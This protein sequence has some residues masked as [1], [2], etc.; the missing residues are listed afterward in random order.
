MKKYDVVYILKKDAPADELRYS[1]RSV[2][3]NLPYRKIW[4]YCGKPDGIEPDEYVKHIQTGPTKWERAKSSVIEICKNDDITEKFWL[5]N[6]DF[7]ILQ[8]IRSEE[9][10]HRGLLRDH[11]R[12]VESRH[13]NSA[14]LYTRELRRCYGLL[15][16]AGY[17][18]LSYAIHAPMLVERAKM[19]EALKA[20][21]TCPMF[22]SIYGNYAK[23]GGRMQKDYKLLNTTDKPDRDAP[24]LST[25]NKTF[26]GDVTRF[27]ME[28]FPEPSKYETDRE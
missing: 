5:F 24:V 7:F 14:T 16:D 1:I 4:F 13:G 10:H 22:R 8:P 23:I 6:D 21:P 2:V 25:S 19:L 18:S 28:T 27:I 15:R 26:S 20:F 11:I 3:K 17:S 12:E 9:P